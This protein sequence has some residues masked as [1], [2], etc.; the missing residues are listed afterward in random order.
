[1]FTQTSTMWTIESPFLC[2]VI[3][4]WKTDQSLIINQNQLTK[5]SETAQFENATKPGKTEQ[6]ISSPQPVNLSSIETHLSRLIVPAWKRTKVSK[7][8]QLVI[9]TSFSGKSTIVVPSLY[10]IIY[11]STSKTTYRSLP[12]Y[13]FGI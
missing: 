13:T 7:T 5:D 2:T 11:C 6:Y 3:L 4:S 1:M 8:E 12:L 9:S 10:I